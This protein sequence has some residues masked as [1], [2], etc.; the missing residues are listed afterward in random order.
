MSEFIKVNRR[1]IM[2]I[3]KNVGGIDQILR[4]ITG[5]ILLLLVSL[6]VIGPQTT[7]LTWNL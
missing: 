7:W 5:S 2:N 4:I 3:T 6:T 1:N